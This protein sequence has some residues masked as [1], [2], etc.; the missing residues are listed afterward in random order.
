MKRR[1]GVTEFV[2]WFNIGGIDKAHVECAMKL[3]AE[4]VMPNV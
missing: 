3:A 1:F 4:Q 2:F